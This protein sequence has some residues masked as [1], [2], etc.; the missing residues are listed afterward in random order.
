MNKILTLLLIG[1]C[2]VNVH[3][4]GITT[5]AIGGAAAGLAA[6]A[7]LSSSTSSAKSASA[8]PVIS[9]RTIL[10]C[11]QAFNGNAPSVSPM[12][13]LPYN[14]KVSLQEYVRV[15]GYKKITNLSMQI[16]GEDMYYVLQVE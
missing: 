3:A 14:G 8:T 16:V 4:K 5:A 15:H 11:K 10:M 9:D 13:A 7:A 1:A 12:C 2:A 6:G